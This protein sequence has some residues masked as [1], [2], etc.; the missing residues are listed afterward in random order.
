MSS[1]ITLINTAK[2]TLLFYINI[3]NNQAK[4]DKYLYLV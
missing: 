3:S 1:V 2:K 4:M